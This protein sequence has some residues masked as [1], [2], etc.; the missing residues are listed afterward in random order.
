M[1]QSELQKEKEQRLN[2]QAENTRL[3]KKLSEFIKQS[4]KEINHVKSQ[5]RGK[6]SGMRKQTDEKARNK[7]SRNGNN[8]LIDFSVFSNSFKTES[9]ISVPGNDLQNASE[10]QVCSN[11]CSN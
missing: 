5:L 7:Y 6:S 8:G 1:K 3:N 9:N 2:L 11:I 10:T 4:Q